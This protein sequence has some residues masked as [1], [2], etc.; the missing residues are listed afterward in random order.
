MCPSCDFTVDMFV[1]MQAIIIPSHPATHLPWLSKASLSP[2]GIPRG[3]E[4]G[5]RPLTHPTESS[6]SACQC[7]L[8]FVT[9]SASSSTTCSV[10]AS[11]CPD[12][13]F[14]AYIESLSTT[15]CVHCPHIRLLPRVL[16]PSCPTSCHNAFL[17][18][19]GFLD[20]LSNVITRFSSTEHTFVT[21]QQFPTKFIHF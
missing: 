20:S 1:D 10:F 12:L 2:L 19:F 7:H 4:S 9:S 17:A 5:I 11:S 18:I 16:S 14:T 8:L 13:C 21:Q 15:T 6:V 3:D